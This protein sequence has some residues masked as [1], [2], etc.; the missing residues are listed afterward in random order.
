[1]TKS[2]KRT[3][4]SKAVKHLSIPHPVT[5]EQRDR[6]IAVA[7]YYIAERRGFAA[8]FADKDWAQAELE[9]DRLLTPER[10]HA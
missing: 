3:S 4:R 8:G 5:P 10:P 1:M 6:Y 7:A 2:D 9:T